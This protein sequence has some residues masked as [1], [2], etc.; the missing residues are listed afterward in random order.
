[1]RSVCRSIAVAAGLAGLVTGAT[2]EVEHIE[3]MPYP[4]VASLA[5]VA[6]TIVM[7]VVVGSGGEVMNAKPLSGP[8]LLAEAS[9]VNARRWRFRIGRPGVAYLVYEFSKSGFCMERC[10][11]TFTVI[12]PR[13]VL[14]QKGTP[15]INP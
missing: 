6:G 12:S 8:K 4:T 9:E 5:M 1:M 3:S 13:H 10:E 15:P 2:P 11:S 7:R 14:I